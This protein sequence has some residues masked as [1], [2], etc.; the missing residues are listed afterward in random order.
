MPATVALGTAITGTA[1]ARASITLTH[2]GGTSPPIWALIGWTKRPGAPLSSTVA[3]FGVIEAET[4]HALSDVDEHRRR[5]LSRRQRP[6]DHDVGAGPPPALFAIDPSLMLPT[7]SRRG[8]IAVEVWGRVRIA[9]TVVA[10][11]MSSCAASRSPALR[12]G[13]SSTQREYGSAGKR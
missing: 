8:E 12:S 1:P 5:H 9:T 2:V 7:P 4:R 3:P 6:E 11:K 10:P 13:R